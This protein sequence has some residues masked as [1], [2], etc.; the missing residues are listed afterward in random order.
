MK[1]GRN[2]VC[3]DYPTLRGHHFRMW[4]DVSTSQ[5]GRVPPESVSHFLA[6]NLAS[7]ARDSQGLLLF[8]SSCSVVISAR[9]YVCCTNKVDVLAQDPGLGYVLRGFR[10]LLGRKKMF[11]ACAYR[12]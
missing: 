7:I 3:R 9:E 10:N 11:H 6:A 2:V 8:V 1:C 4:G 5:I 12:P